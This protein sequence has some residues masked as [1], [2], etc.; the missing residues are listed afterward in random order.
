MDVIYPHCVGLDIHMQAVVAYVRIASDGA[1]QQQVRTFATTTFSGLLEMADGTEAFEVRHVAMEA[2]GVYWKPMWH[3]L[4]DH[5]ELILANAAHAT[6]VPGRKIDVYDAMW[7]VNLRTQGLIRASFVPPAQGQELCT[8]TQLVRRRSAHVLRIEKVLEDTNLKLGV[9]L[10]YILAVLQAIVDGYDA[11]ESLAY[12]MNTRIKASRAELLEARRGRVTAHHR[13]MLKLHQKKATGSF[14][15]DLTEKLFDRSYPGHYLRQIKLVPTSLPTMLSPYQDVPAT[16]TQTKSSTLLK[17]DVSGVQCGNGDLQQGS[18]ANLVTNFRASEQIALSSEPERRRPV[19]AEL[20]RRTLPAVR[21][22]RRRI[23]LDAGIPAPRQIGHA[24]GAAR[25]V[26]RRDRPRALH[27][28]G[29]RGV[30][31]PASRGHA[32]RLRHRACSLGPFATVPPG[33][34][35]HVQDHVGA[36]VSGFSGFD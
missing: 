1:P 30:L 29:W 3:V 32:D 23:E 21:G 22:D 24:K 35:P 33:P 25:C 20:G 6:D 5:F 7:L 11:T 19:R 18:A 28:D 9:G 27:T 13:F 14:D 4:E 26:D 17:A 36:G 10:T 31:C 16:L 8:R 12:C 15:F 2:T 34:P